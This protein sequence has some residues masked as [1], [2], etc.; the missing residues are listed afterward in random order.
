MSALPVL[1]RSLDPVKK[2]QPTEAWVL[3]QELKKIFDVRE[4]KLD[5]QRIPD[6]VKVLM[7]IH[8]RNL[9][10]ETEYAIDQYVLKGGKLL[11]F[12]Y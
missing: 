11:A 2:Q 6:E 8:P 7:V 4:V 1:G 9:S 3:I 12:V 10:E 5:A